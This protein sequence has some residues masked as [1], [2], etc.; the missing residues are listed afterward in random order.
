M[1]NSLNF[2]AKI[3]NAWTCKKKKKK[4]Q[5]F[6]E[7]AH[8]EKLLFNGNW[9][10]LHEQIDLEIREELN[11][12]FLWYYE[13]SLTTKAKQHKWMSWSMN[14]WDGIKN[15]YDH[16]KTYLLRYSQKLIYVLS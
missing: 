5:F 4:K 6:N 8:L 3:L 2:I 13:V 12:E 15:R 7:I 16:I 9:S 10:Y 14:C 1:K 11:N